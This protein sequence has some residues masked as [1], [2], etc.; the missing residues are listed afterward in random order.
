MNDLDLRKQFIENFGEEK[1]KELDVLSQL[2]KKI[3]SISNKWFGIDMPVLI[4]TNDI[5]NECAR[6]NVKQDLIL[7]NSKYIN[8]E[9]E[10]LD[11]ILHELEH[12]YQLCYVASCNTPKAKR[13]KNELENYKDSKNPADNLCQE[14]E[15]DAIATAQLI[16][17]CE[18]GIQR[19][20][21][22]EKLQNIID[23]YIESRKIL[24]E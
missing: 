3:L 11:S 19:K 16:M 22:D 1:L 5:D 20:L 15:I 14:I 17:K 9:E 10:L 23:Y 7:L 8:D 12:K 24:E 21:E 2:E 4:F 18:F 6:Y 13:W